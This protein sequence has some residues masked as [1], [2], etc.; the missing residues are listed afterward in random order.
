MYK[1]KYCTMFKKINTSKE[2][3]NPYLMTKS[4]LNYILTISTM[5]F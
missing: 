2:S 3:E 4:R 1:C 5:Y